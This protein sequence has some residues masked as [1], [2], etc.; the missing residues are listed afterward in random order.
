EDFENYK[1]LFK[2]FMAPFS[3]DVAEAPLNLQL[4]LI[5]LQSDSALR[6]K[7]N[8]VGVPAIYSHLND[9]YEQIKEFVAKILCMFGS[10]YLCEQLFSCMKLNKNMFRSRLSDKNLS[11]IMKISCS[12][13][14]TPNFDSLIDDKTRHK[15]SNKKNNWLNH[16]IRYLLNLKFIPYVKIIYASFHIILKAHFLCEKVMCG[17]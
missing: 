9:R 8:E 7:Y 15:S 1:T 10:T 5:D 4:E 12:Q 3:F 11:S 16:Y 6:E 2:L 14:L 17:P 13:K